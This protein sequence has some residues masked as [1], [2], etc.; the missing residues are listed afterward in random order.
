MPKITLNGVEVEVADGLN[1]IQAAETV[2]VTIPHYCYHPGLPIDGNCRMCL[3]EVEGA[4]GPQIACNT[5]VKEGMVVKTDTPAVEKMRKGVQEFLLLNHPIDCPICDQAGECRLQ[6]YYMEYGQYDNRSM[7]EKVEKQKA[8]DLG[9][10]VVLDQERC[11][12]CQRCVR[13][14][15]AVTKTGELVVAN[16]GDH[17]AIETFP[18]MELDNPYSVN[19]VDLCPVGA[20]TSKDFRFK[21]RVWFLQT[22]KSVCTG[23]SKGCAIDVDHKDGVVYRYRPRENPQVNQYWMCDEGRF[24]YKRINEDRLRTALIEGR[25]VP[26][27]TA[28]D[29]IITK[30]KSVVELYGAES[31]AVV[32]SPHST[33]EDNFLLNRLAREVIGTSKVWALALTPDGSHDDFLRRADKT[34][35]RTGIRFLGYNDDADSLKAA[36]ASGAVR[37]LVMMNTDLFTE[38]DASWQ[39]ALAKVPTTVMFATHDTAGAR[40]VGVTLPIAMQA[41][42]YGSFV[43]EDGVLQKLMRAFDPSGDV[44]PEWE[45]LG[46]LAAKLGKSLGYDDMEQ[47]WEDLGKT[48]PALAGQTFYALPEHG[49]KLPAGAGAA[50]VAVG[51]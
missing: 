20:L 43:Q 21:Q 28:V 11:I 30:L 7:V 42:K 34:P 12:L 2:G 51:R 16:R 26:Y 23:C 31:V 4:R 15:D 27:G 49:L 18:G 45:A 50:P 5:F 10:T 46:V 47:I 24:S 37:M 9:P 14:T 13:F 41:E 22:A 40:K 33:I 32:G 39:E 25:E 29:A 44:L 19:V 8:V 17:S 35:N 48:Y 3:T 36:L 38:G 6:D 1:L